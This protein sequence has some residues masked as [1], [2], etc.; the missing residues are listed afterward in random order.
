MNTP[1][2]IQDMVIHPSILPPE[3]PLPRIDTELYWPQVSAR[4]N[5]SLSDISEVIW[6]REPQLGEME[7]YNRLQSYLAALV[8][9]DS[10]WGED[11]LDYLISIQRDEAIHAMVMGLEVPMAQCMGIDSGGLEAQL[12]RL[13]GRDKPALF[14]AHAHLAAT[15][16]HWA[17]QCADIPNTQDKLV[18]LTDRLDLYLF[19]TPSSFPVSAF[20]E[21]LRRAFQPY[22][23]HPIRDLTHGQRPHSPQ[24]S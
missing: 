24:P 11:L 7:V 13:V 15:L 4:Y 16:I 6:N 8:Y 9:A 18:S 19:Q 21:T 14:L 17:W 1:R 23:R 10:L 3:Q 12:L 20:T 22:N 2:E 5:L